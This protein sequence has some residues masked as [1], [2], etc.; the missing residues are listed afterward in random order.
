MRVLGSLQRLLVV[1]DLVRSLGSAGAPALVFYQQ[2]LREGEGV[3]EGRGGEGEGER[4]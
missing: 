4:E 1:N 3:E 2:Y